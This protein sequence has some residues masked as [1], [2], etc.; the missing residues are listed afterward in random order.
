[1][2]AD[3]GK[4]TAGSE[5]GSADGGKALRDKL[6]VTQES[7]DSSRRENDELK[8]RLNDLQGQLE[9]LQRLMQLKDDQLAKLQAQ[10]GAEGQVPGRPVPRM[11]VRLSRLL[12]RRLK[13]VPLTKAPHLMSRRLA[14]AQ[15]S[16]TLRQSP[17]LPPLSVLRRRSLP[18]P[19]R[20]PDRSPRGRA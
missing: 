12:A 20:R 14:R 19:P 16:K 18:S 5:T 3:A 8:D 7:L 15:V 2:A 17:R 11:P 1:M 9:K 4:S 10:L 6:A 13:A